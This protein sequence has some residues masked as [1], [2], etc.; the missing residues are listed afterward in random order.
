MNLQVAPRLHVHVQL[1]DRLCVLVDE[2]VVTA[3]DDATLLRIDVDVG[4]HVDDARLRQR[5]V[6]A[7]VLLELR[8]AIEHDVAPADI[9]SATFVL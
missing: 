4:V 7:I 2:P 5:P 8:L 9:R 3:N 1:V 6:L